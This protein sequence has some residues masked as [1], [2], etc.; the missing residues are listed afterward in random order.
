MGERWEYIC[1][2]EVSILS[3]RRNVG[4]AELLVQTVSARAKEPLN[5][6]L[7]PPW[8]KS[9]GF[10]LNSEAVFCYQIP[11]WAYSLPEPLSRQLYPKAKDQDLAT[12]CECLLPA[13]D[14]E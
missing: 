5:Q 4:R 13:S 12:G 10:Q 3:A 1:L 11:F 2:G 14:T 7:C 8:E 9:G 6:P